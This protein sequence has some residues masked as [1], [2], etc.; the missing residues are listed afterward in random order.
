M[1]SGAFAV[2]HEK[3]VNFPLI[4]NCC[5]YS[6]RCQIV[7]VSSSSLLLNSNTSRA[8]DKHLGDRSQDELAGGWAMYGTVFMFRF[9]VAVLLPPYKPACHPQSQSIA[10]KASSGPRVFILGDCDCDSVYQPRPSQPTN[11]ST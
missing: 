8:A 2:R 4:D 6:C 7:H 11:T 10:F 1:I 9:P 3:T 5:P